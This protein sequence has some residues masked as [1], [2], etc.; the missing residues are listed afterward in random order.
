[1]ACAPQEVTQFRSCHTPDSQNSARHI[2]G[3]PKPPVGH[4]GAEVL[5]S[6]VPLFWSTGA[7]SP[8][9]A[10]AE[11]GGLSAGLSGDLCSILGWEQPLGD[12]S[13]TI[14]RGAELLMHEDPKKAA[15]PRHCWDQ[16]ALSVQSPQFPP[17][18]QSPPQ[19]PAHPQHKQVFQ[20]Q[21]AKILPQP[22]V[23]GHSEARAPWMHPTIPHADFPGHPQSA[24]QERAP[25]Q[26][27]TSGPICT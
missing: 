1:M 22:G 24:L 7:W 3:A 8:P 21:F 14:R 13:C 9:R 15:P 2:A 5:A 19:E 27:R 16:K 4:T 23:G 11:R 20:S 18:I 10:G 12:E 6:L 25:P 17:L 26:A